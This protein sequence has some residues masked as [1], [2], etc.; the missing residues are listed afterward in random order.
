[1][2]PEVF[3]GQVPVDGLRTIGP[4]A[5]NVRSAGIALL[6]V[7]VDPLRNGDNRNNPFFWTIQE[8]EEKPE[9]D[10]RR[11]DIS[12]PAETR[13][14]GETREKNLLGA[15]AEFCD[16]QSLP[17]LR[18]HLFMAEGVFRQR[19]IN[20]NGNLVD[21]SALIYDGSLDHPLN[22]LNRT[23]VA[24][25]KWLTRPQIKSEI[26]VRSVLTQALDIDEREGLTVRMIDLYNQNRGI[27]KPVF[28][29]DFTTLEEFYRTREILTDIPL[30]K[31]EATS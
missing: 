16:D 27:L 11:G 12:I 22:P 19:G 29:Q 1:M 10:K 4:E 28:P 30:K 21:V 5:P 18:E 6:I 26:R 2:T 3:L 9:T 7:G 17:Y 31:R 8:L 14:I 13:K 20:I 23:E 25:N 15:F 24:P